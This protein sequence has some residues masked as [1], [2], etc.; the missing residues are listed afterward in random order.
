VSIR[1]NVEEEMH[2]DEVTTA[3]ITIVV[4]SGDFCCYSSFFLRPVQ[5][6]T[7]R[8]KFENEGLRWLAERRIT[9]ELLEYDMKH[10]WLPFQRQATIDL[11][12]M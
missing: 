9:G 12:R 4:S 2:I 7:L 1:K 11:N 10:V 8:A 5:W 3:Q 6:S